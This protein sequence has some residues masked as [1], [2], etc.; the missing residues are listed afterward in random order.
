MGLSSATCWLQ[1][2]SGVGQPIENNSA[3]FCGTLEISSLV[4]GEFMMLKQ[5]SRLGFVSSACCYMSR[6]WSDASLWMHLKE[7]ALNFFLIFER[8]NEYFK[9]FSSTAVRETYILAGTKFKEIRYVDVKG[10]T[11]GSI[12]SCNTRWGKGDNVNV[13]QLT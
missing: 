11:N 5:W 2:S 3:K 6:K 12:C 10:G 4:F 13:R 9:L 7:F 1:L 8:G